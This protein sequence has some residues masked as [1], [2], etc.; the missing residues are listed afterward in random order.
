ME[1]E[2]FDWSQ[3]RTLAFA[4]DTFRVARAYA[5]AGITYYKL[6]HGSYEFDLFR[7]VYEYLA[8]LEEAVVR[9][10]EYPDLIIKPGWE[11]KVASF[12]SAE[13]YCG[14]FYFNFNIILV[15]IFVSF[16]AFILTETGV[17]KCVTD[18]A[19]FKFLSPYY[20]TERGL[21]D[22]PSASD[23]WRKGVAFRLVSPH[24]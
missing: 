14:K 4:F 5:I 24:I 9:L 1:Q 8:S 18:T 3:I 16:S 23:L 15:V 13:H 21:C 7:R 2:N 22:A 10:D 20:D 12:E 6:T 11:H 17:K 19:L